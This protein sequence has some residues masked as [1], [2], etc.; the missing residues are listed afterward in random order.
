MSEVECPTCKGKGKEVVL[1]AGT[2]GQRGSF[3]L[4]ICSDCQGAGKVS[5]EASGELAKR[6]AAL[7]QKLSSGKIVIS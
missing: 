6:D 3:N 7:K 4:A 5:K 2:N 1:N